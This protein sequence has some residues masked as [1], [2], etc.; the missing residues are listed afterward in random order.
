MHPGLVGFRRLCANVSIRTPPEGGVMPEYEL[1]KAQEEIVSIRTPPEGGV[2]HGLLEIKRD[3][4][5]FQSAP[6]PKAG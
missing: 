5:L 4:I 6:R 3:F 2:M 1:G